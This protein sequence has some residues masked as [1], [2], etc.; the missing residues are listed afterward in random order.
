MGLKEQI[1]NDIFGVFLNLCDFGEFHTINGS[2]L[3]GLIDKNNVHMR[4]S[5]G[6]RTEGVRE[7][8]FFLYIKAAEFVTL[9]K[10]YEPIEV[11]GKRYTI[12]SVLDEMGLLVIEY[13][14]VSDGRRVV[15]DKPRAL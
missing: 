6:R 11:D 8:S 7:D 1:E 13:G 15:G 3:L 9:P 4:A 14:G 5:T 10:P 2:R 12:R